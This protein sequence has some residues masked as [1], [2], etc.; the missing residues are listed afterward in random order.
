MYY[1]QDCFVSRIRRTDILQL[2]RPT[3]S[4]RLAFTRSHFKRETVCNFQNF[5][6]Q[7][8]RPNS[9]HS[10]R[11]SPGI[12]RPG[13]GQFFNSQRASWNI[14]RTGGN[15]CPVDSR[16]HRRSLQTPSFRRVH[17]ENANK[18]RQLCNQ[19]RRWN[20][21]SSYRSKYMVRELPA[22]SSAGS[23]LLEILTLSINC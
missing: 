15:Y 23:K 17:S 11:S 1:N 21:Y 20:Q 12:F 22:S 13:L 14:Y 2:A 18:L 7:K 5:K 6:S 8:S 10:R 3:K 16:I 4:N 9:S 19:L